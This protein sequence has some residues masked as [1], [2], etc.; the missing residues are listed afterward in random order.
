MQAQAEVNLMEN[1]F[2]MGRT[3]EA[4]SRMLAFE[5]LSASPDFDLVRHRWSTRMKDLK[6]TIFLGKGDLVA[7]ENIANECFEM[8]NKTQMAPAAHQNGP[9]CTH[10]EWTPTTDSIRE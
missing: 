9:L 5:A 6:G 3:E 7:A 2:E 1:Q 4:S 8:A 10:E